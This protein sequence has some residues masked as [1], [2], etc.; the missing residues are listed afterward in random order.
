V[1]IAYDYQTTATQ[2][3]TFVISDPNP[4][5]LRVHLATQKCEAIQITIY[6]SSDQT[7]TEESDDAFR[8]R[9]GGRHQARRSQAS[10]WQSG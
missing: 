2:T 1:A 5:Q 7:G 10:R 8:A 4:Y 3:N 9:A 6:D